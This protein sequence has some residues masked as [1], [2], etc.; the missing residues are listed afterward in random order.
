MSSE[1]RKEAEIL[2]SQNPQVCIP[3]LCSLL[4]LLFAKYCTQVKRLFLISAVCGLITRIK[5]IDPKHILV[6]KI[7]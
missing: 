2:C 1:T 6:I 3:A 4:D 7:T 5:E